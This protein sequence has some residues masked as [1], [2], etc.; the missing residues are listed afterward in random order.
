MTNSPIWVH[1]WSPVGNAYM[2]AYLQGDRQGRHID[3]EPREEPTARRPTTKHKTKNKKKRQR[4]ERKE[5]ALES[6]SRSRSRGHRCRSR[7]CNVGMVRDFPVCSTRCSGERGGG[8]G[9]SKLPLTAR[10]GRHTHSIYTIVLNKKGPI[11]IQLPYL[12][13]P[14]SRVASRRGAARCYSC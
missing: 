5:E 11:R 6:C 7:S 10:D 4:L 9:W 12:S 3:W 8:Y 2:S 13:Q 14:S 1:V